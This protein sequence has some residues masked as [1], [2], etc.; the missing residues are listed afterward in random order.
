M[1]HPVVPGSTTAATAPEKDRSTEP[2]SAPRGFLARIALAQFGL[3]GALITPVIITMALR[4]A[5]VDPD[6]KTASLSLVLGVGALF[7][8]IANPLFG[9]LSDRTT[10]RFGRRRPWLICGVAGGFA[11]LSIIAFVP[12]IPAILVG[13]I[14]TQTALNAS[15]AT[16]QATVPDQV[17]PAQRGKV[18]GALGVAI[19]LSVVVS[20][21]LASQIPGQGA[22][23]LA[24]AVL[25]V[26]FVTY[27]ALTLRDKPLT[28]K[29]GPFSAKEFAHSF[30]ASPRTHPDF[31]WAWLSKFLVMFGMVGPSAY[32][33]YYLMSDFGVSG[34]K[35]ALLVIVGSL[36]NA[37][38]AAVSGWLSDRAGTRKPFVIGSSLVVVAGLLLVAFAPSFPIILLSQVVIGIGGGMFYAVDMALVTEV[39]P[40]PDTAAKDLGVM[41]IANALPQSLG[42]AVAPFLLAIGGGDNY[43]LFFAFCA[44]VALV[45]AL[46]VT[47]IKSV[48]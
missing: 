1:D 46:S 47:R 29:P 13:W 42:P 8:L 31:G 24:P 26:V 23:F 11:G 3:F 32:T 21:V 37:A 19:T 16:L 25:A 45:G 12:S 22:Q 10:S 34:G 43:T 18:S 20:M 40:D 38:S 36:C 7:A 5:E 35:I 9:R 15:L 33:A 14:I 6:N 48:R 41:N 30:W 17:P 44:A 2:Q 4:V 39:L 28:A 27:F